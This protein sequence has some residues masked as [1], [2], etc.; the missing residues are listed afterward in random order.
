ML[1]LICGP[2]KILIIETPA[3]EQIEFMVLSVKGNQV[4]T[5]TVAPDNISI[6]REELYA[7]AIT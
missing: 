5:G 1:I 3:G 4:R 6:V 7:P 2:S